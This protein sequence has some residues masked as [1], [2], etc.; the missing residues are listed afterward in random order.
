[1]KTNILKKIWY[2]VWE[3]TLGELE[4][5]KRYYAKLDKVLKGVDREYLTSVKRSI[6]EGLYFNAKTTLIDP[7]EYFKKN[8]R[9]HWFDEIEL[10]NNSIDGVSEDKDEHDNEFYEEDY[11]D[12]DPDTETFEWE[13]DMLDVHGRKGGT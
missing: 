6:N 9:T 4:V 13:D 2:S 11:G 3:E 10:F 1:M 12:F 8:T 7:I 5:Q